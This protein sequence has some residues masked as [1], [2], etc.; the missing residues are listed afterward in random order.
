MNDRPGPWFYASY[1]SECVWGDM[2]EEGDRIRAD[3]AGGWEH[4]GCAEPDDEEDEPSN[5][6]AAFFGL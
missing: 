5:E 6:V 3:G 4:E 2:I 1:D